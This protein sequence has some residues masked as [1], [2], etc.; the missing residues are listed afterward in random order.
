MQWLL[1]RRAVPD[2]LRWLL[3]NLLA[4]ALGISGAG[5][6]ERS[7]L[8]STNGQWGAQTWHNGLTSGLAGLIVGL[9]TGVALAVMFFR[10]NPA[11][12][13]AE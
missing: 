5:W 10:S 3:A 1:F 9:V 13:G 8:I 2:Y 12:G 7:L 11:S 6:L 4:F